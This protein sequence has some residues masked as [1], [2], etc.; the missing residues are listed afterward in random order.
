MKKF[1]GIEE[2]EFSKREV[3]EAGVALVLSLIIIFSSLY[4]G[5]R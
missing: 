2:D 4:F 3:L 1:F 5:G